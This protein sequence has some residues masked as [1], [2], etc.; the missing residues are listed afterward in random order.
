MVTMVTAVFVSKQQLS[1]N[2][3]MW[4]TQ[5]VLTIVADVDQQG[6]NFDQKILYYEVGCKLNVGL[7]CDDC[8]FHQIE[9]HCV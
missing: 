4:I 6:A 2:V 7:G 3:I 5:I 1:V 8:G 9:T